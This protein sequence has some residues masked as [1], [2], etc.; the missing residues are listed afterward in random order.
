MRES[1]ADTVQAVVLAVVL[2][3]LLAAL[4][5]IGFG[6]L[7]KTAEPAAGAPVVEA[8]MVDV[9]D[10]S[11]R[12]Q[13]V[14]ANRQ[15]AEAVVAEPESA[16]LP[17]ALD[18]ADASAPPPP[19]PAPQA[20]LMPPQPASP[21]PQVKPDT[22]EQEEVRRE[23]L[24]REKREREQEARRRQ[25]QIELQRRQEQQAAEQKRRQ[26][27]Q[28]QARERAEREARSKAEAE[29]KARTERETR[30]RAEAEQRRRR[31]EVEAKARTEREA[32]A[33]AE[34]DA[35]AR[36]D[37]EARAKALAEA[38]A[39]QQAD[40]Q[41]RAAARNAGAGG[42]SGAAQGQGRDT[43]GEWLALVVGEIEKQWRRPE[44]VPP[45]Q[46]CPIRIRLLPGGEVLSA[47]VQASCPY[48]EANRRSVEAAVMRASPL[49]LKGNE[50]LAIRDFVVNFYPSR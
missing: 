44:E 27:E 45:G 39:Q 2:H 8:E 14:L 28:Q 20:P 24:N 31:A 49:P 50:N 9:G 18:E 43:R 16:P 33:K 47:E 42:N 32:R 34:A 36:A 29:A 22:R 21:P 10:L 11:A 26:A 23:A 5:F 35:K 6:W 37:R 1:R 4:I 3:L 46:R 40:A 48:S 30:A 17:E 38:R 19:E 13:R 7:R 15:E 25:E 12:M 41:A